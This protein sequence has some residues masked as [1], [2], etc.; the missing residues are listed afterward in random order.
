MQLGAT[1]P[2]QGEYAWGHN[3]LLP[4]TTDAGHDPHAILTYPANFDPSQRYPLILYQYERLSQGLHRYRPPSRTDYYNVQ[5][6]SQALMRQV[7]VW[8]RSVRKVL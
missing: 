2:F 8:S 1:N 7:K 3:E 4:Y 6:W 5:V